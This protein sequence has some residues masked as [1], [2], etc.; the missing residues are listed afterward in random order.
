MRPLVRQANQAVKNFIETGEPLPCP[1]PLPDNLKQKA[2][3]FVTLRN[4]GALRGCIGTLTPKYNNLAEEVI[5]NAIRSASEDPRFD[6]VEKRELPSLTFSVDV[7][8]PEE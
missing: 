1:D 8:I 7:L 5:K 3:T 6:R 4:Q 2:G